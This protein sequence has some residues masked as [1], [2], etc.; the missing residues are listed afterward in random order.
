M[1]L[2]SA[3]GLAP[4]PQQAGVV[5]SS[6]PPPNQHSPNQ[7][8]HTVIVQAPTTSAG[9]SHQLVELVTTGAPNASNTVISRVY[10]SDGNTYITSSPATLGSVVS[11]LC[12]KRVNLFEIFFLYY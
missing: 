9:Q 2:Q 1:I 11:I 5:I 4:S 8:A 7:S 6:T 3:G 12:I 10:G